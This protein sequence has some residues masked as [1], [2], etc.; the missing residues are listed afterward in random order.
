MPSNQCLRR[1]EQ[2]RSLPKLILERNDAVLEHL[3]LA[4]HAAIYQAARYPG[5]QD[6]LVQEGRLGLINGMANFDPQRGLRISTY[7]LARVH[8]QILHF[9][10]DRQHTLRIP[11]RLKDLH[12]RGMRLQAQRLQQR[13]EP[14]DEPGLAASLHV[15]PQRWREAL[16]AH[17][18]GHVESLDVAPSIQ[19]VEGGLRSSLLDLIEDSSSV[20]SSL[21]ET[22]LRWLQDALQTLEPQQRS[23]LLARYVDNIPIKDLALREKVHPGLLR[24]SIR[25]ALSMLRQAAK[26]TTAQPLV[27]QQVPK[28][29]RSASPRRR[30]KR[31]ATR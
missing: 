6:D 22:T 30:P 23:W 28:G 2:R 21:D 13:L 26:S 5:E 24:K 20:P 31:F 12:R 11:W 16:I 15:S 4:H 8:G 14:L 1:R 25:A 17:A 7:V 18:F 3:G 27:N 9:R 10:R 29:P 19:A